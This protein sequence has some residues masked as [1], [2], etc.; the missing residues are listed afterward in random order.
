MCDFSC[1]IFNMIDNP[2]TVITIII[3]VLLNSGLMQ[4]SAKSF[5]R[6]LRQMK[7]GMPHYLREG[8]VAGNYIVRDS[9]VFNYI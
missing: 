7:G 3:L 2:K 1:Q 4:S 5:T 6:D 8:M 9:I